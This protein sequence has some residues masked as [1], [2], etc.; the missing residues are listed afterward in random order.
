VASEFGVFRRICSLANQIRTFP[1]KVAAWSQGVQRPAISTLTL[2]RSGPRSLVGIATDY[3]LDGPGI[4]SRWGRDFPPFQTG[5]GAHPTSCTMGT[6]SLLEVKCGRDVLLTT[7]HLLG[8]R[9]WKSRVIPLPPLGH[10][11][12]CNGVT[13]ALPCHEPSVT[14]FY[15]I[16]AL[17]SIFVIKGIMSRRSVPGYRD[18]QLRCARSSGS[19]LK[20]KY[21]LCKKYASRLD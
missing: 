19:H 16:P 13:L 1:G 21:M 2:P 11:R 6:G 7:H 20:S 17:F 15:I 5:P 12:A 9:S 3:G 18:I 14:D 10:N 4:E 8:P